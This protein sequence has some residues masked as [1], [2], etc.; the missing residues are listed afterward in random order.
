MILVTAASGNAGQA[1][2]R[3]L[4]RGG[5]ACRALVRDP[6]KTADW[7]LG[8]VEIARGDLL[9]AGSLDAAMSG[10]E[11]LML[12]SPP[13][14][15]GGEMEIAAIDAAVRGGVKRIVK[16]SSAGADLKSSV[17]FCRTHGESEKKMEQS[18]LEWTHL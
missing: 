2:V 6:A 11:T 4:S 7:N 17:R 8:G 13:N 18:G 14:S 16:F 15:R 9:D 3:E 1:I 5:V 10:V 12:I